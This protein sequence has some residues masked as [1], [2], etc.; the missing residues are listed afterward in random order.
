MKTIAK[1]NYTNPQMQIVLIQ[2]Q[3]SLLAGSPNYNPGLDP[4]DN[5]EGGN[6]Y[7]IGDD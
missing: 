4:R 2:N 7:E 3:Q 5:G 1:K 6:G